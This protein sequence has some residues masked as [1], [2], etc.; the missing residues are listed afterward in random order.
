MH[1]RFVRV[2]QS[3]AN[4]FDLVADHSLTGE[5]D[6]ML[7]SITLNFASQLAFDPLH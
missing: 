5:V 3:I 6:F 7:F 2:S 1:T 4:N